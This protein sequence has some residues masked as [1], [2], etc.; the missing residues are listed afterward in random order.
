MYWKPKPQLEI[1]QRA[2]ELTK[3]YKR[4]EYYLGVKP[5]KT[6]SV[7]PEKSSSQ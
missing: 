2:A 6:S 4:N 7:K 3:E 1:T 5:I